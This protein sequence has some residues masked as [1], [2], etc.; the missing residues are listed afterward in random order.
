V[1]TA[2]PVALVTPSTRFNLTS[3]PNPA[4][5]EVVLRYVLN[6]AG[7]VRV[8]VYT[9]LGRYIRT[10][11]EGWQPAG[12]KSILWQGEDEDGRHLGRGIYFY[13]VDAEGTAETARL[14]LVK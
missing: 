11:Y 3:Y 6:E 13:R 4:V 9:L 8:R 14:V 5:G 7:P 12:S 10:L 2:V 1:T